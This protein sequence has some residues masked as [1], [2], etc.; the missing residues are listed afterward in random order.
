VKKLR[1]QPADTDAA[2]AAQLL[3]QQPQQMHS[4]TALKYHIPQC[5]TLV[6]CRLSSC[7]AAHRNSALIVPQ[8]VCSTGVV[9][10]GT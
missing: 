1:V 10:T 9:A 7:T 5:R 2:P 8:L 3:W 4:G 6:L